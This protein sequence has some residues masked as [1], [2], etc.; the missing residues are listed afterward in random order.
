MSQKK[1]QVFINGKK[2]AL[3]GNKS[4]SDLLKNLAIV[5]NGIAIEINPQLFLDHNIKIL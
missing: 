1:I 3:K 4:L 5:K 2:K